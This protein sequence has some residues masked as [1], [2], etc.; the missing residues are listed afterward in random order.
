MKNCFKDWSQSRIDRPCTQRSASDNLCRLLIDIENSLDPDQDQSYL[1]LCDCDCSLFDVKSA[2]DK[3]HASLPSKYS[4]L[5][6]YNR[7]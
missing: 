6:C 2:D 4:Y 1:I 7:K 3:I 5:N